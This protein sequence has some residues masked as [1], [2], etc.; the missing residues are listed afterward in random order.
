MK[1]V[2]DVNQEARDETMSKQHGG[3]AKVIITF[4]ITVAI[5][6]LSMSRYLPVTP[7]T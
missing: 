3:R 5:H 1:H 4:A 7:E 2:T 6:T